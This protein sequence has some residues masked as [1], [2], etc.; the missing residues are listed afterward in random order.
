MAKN[1]KE[2][3]RTSIENLN[4]HLSSFEQKL[5]KNK[6]HVY[7]AVGVILA[8][9]IGFFAIKMIN[10]NKFEKDTEKLGTALTE[11]STNDST[12]LV[13]LESLFKNSSTKPANL[14]G[15]S[16]AILHYQKGEYKEAAALLEKYE[17]NGKLIGPAAKSLLGDCYVNLK[18]YEKA[19]EAFDA[20]IKGAGDNEA[21]TPLFMLK[22]ATVLHA[23][24]KYAD[25]AKVYQEINDKYPTFQMT[26]GINIEKYLER[27]NAMAG[28]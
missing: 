7:I 20:A 17:A 18:K 23:L 28:K 1:K 6:K 8:I 25:E 24:K 11:L 26:N 10:K 22:K 9:I 13:K 19:V 16:A 2:S 5:E 27:A 14:A 4:E 12:A 15:H 3:A 21:Y